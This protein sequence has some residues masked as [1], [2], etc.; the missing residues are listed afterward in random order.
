MKNAGLVVIKWA[1][2]SYDAPCED[3]DH[4]IVILFSDTEACVAIAF[5]WI[6]TILYLTAQALNFD[7]PGYV[8]GYCHHGMTFADLR[9]WQVQVP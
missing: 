5:S 7:V 6:Q 8:L 4:K 1:H 9:R 2:F 3:S